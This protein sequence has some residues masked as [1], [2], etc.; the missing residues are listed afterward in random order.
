MSGLLIILCGVILLTGCEKMSLMSVKAS[1]MW[2]LFWGVTGYIATL[3]FSNLSRQEVYGLLNIADISTLEFFELLIMLGYIFSGGVL[4]KILSF[5]PGLMVFAPT[6]VVSYFFAGMFP[7]MDFI[8]VG[9]TAA[10]VIALFLT[11]LTLL[12][13]YLRVDS[14]VL[15]KTVLTAVFINIIIYGLL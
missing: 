2:S 9:L 11:G 10:C 4:K 8:L 7:G 13:R 3:V 14:K 15:Y 1:L 12:F 5:Y 6:C